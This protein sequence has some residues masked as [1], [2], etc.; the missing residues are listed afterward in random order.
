MSAAAGIFN[1]VLILLV[2]M[3]YLRLIKWKEVTQ[4]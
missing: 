2:V 3:V 4:A 1:V